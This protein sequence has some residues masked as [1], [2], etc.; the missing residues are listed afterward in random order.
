[1]SQHNSRIGGCL[2]LFFAKQPYYLKH[3][4][5]NP[6]FGCV[7]DG[8]S[9]AYGQG[10]SAKP[11]HWLYRFR[12]NSQ[13]RGAVPTY[14]RN[15][16]G[17]WMHW[18]EVSTIKKGIA[19]MTNHEAQP[20][21]ICG[22]IVSLFTT[23][24]ILRYLLFHPELTVYMLAMYP[25]KEWLTMHR[26]NERHPMDKPVFRWLQ[27]CPEFYWY[28][29]YREFIKLGIIANDPYVDYM[30]SIGRERDLTLYM[31]EKGWG[32]GGQGKIVDLL[33]YDWRYKPKHKEGHH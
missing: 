16:G 27:R 23:W 18:L 14:L 19:G 29:P 24:Q 31:D 26:Y 28:D 9:T 10:F 2:P 11:I 22:I 15:P 6:A 32:E 8:T 25:T 30:K 17:K 4:P 20:H 3:M 33:P 1:M 12:Y 5:M 7:H 21:V 13:H